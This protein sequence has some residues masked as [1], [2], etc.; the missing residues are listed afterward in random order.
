MAVWN[1]KNAG[2]NDNLGKIEEKARASVV[3]SLNR[4]LT[5]PSNL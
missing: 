4:S 3:F 1:G 5:V 2:R